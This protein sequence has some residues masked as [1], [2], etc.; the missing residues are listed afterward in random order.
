MSCRSGRQ[1]RRGNESL[2]SWTGASE[3]TYD[4]P[5]FDEH[6]NTGEPGDEIV[7]C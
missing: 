7:P 5:V 6:D 1:K 2:L 4:A 3:D